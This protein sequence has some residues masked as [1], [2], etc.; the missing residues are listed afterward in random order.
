MQVKK[1]KKV[2]KFPYVVLY[3]YV[4]ITG[5]VDLKLIPKMSVTL[6]YVSP[7]YSP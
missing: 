5:D 3:V 7:C 2:C 1:D 6:V 4:A